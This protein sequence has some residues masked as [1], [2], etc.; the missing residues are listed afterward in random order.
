MYSKQIMQ[1]FLK[2]KYAGKISNPDGVG[3]A[4][5]PQCLLPEEKVHT[6]PSLIKISELSNIFDKLKIRIRMAQ[7]LKL[8][9]EKQFAHIHTYYGREMG[10][11]IG[12]WLKWSNG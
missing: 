9:S 2:P 7:E 10:E 3:R 11:M 4:G 8:I 12:G 1:R 6:N 5:N